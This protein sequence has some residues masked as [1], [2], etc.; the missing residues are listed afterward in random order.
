MVLVD[1]DCLL[2]RASLRLAR[3]LEEGSTSGAEMEDSPMG[4]SKVSAKTAI[5]FPYSFENK[6]EK[7]HL[8]HHFTGHHS[9]SMRKEGL[10]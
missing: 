10:I 2:L 6:R 3:R 9:K 8:I 5:V 1:I 7:K 4:L